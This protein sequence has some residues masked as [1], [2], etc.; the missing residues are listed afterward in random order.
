MDFVSHV[1]FAHFLAWKF[2]FS[3]ELALGSLFPDIDRV[4]AYLNQKFRKA[5]SRTWIQELPFLS[6]VVFVSLMSGHNYF[7]VGVVSHVFLDFVTG[8]TRPFYPFIENKI[9]Y[10]RSLR[11]KALMSVIIWVFGLATIKF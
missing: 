10:N 11:T 8:E 5:E 2:E 6:I 1:F 4:Y 9:D 3:K 7:A